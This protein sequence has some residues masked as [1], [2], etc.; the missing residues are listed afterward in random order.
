MGG[1]GGGG[2]GWG[3]GGCH[4]YMFNTGLTTFSMRHKKRINT[5][6]YMSYICYVLFPVFF[7]KDYIHIKYCLWESNR[8]VRT[9]TSKMYT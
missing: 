1:G 6:V 2:G 4:R 9:G 8:V 3:G 7:R 5:Y